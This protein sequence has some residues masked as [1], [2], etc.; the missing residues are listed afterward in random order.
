M[1]HEAAAVEGICRRRQQQSL[2][3]I[4][5]PH[6]RL[7][8]VHNKYWLAILHKVKLV[9]FRSSR[10]RTSIKA[11]HSL[12]FALAMRH[13]RRGNDRLIHARV[14]RVDVLDVGKACMVYASACESADC[15]LA[16]LA[17]RWAVT[18]VRC[19]A[20]EKSSI[21]IAGENCREIANLS[22]GCESIVHQFAL[23]SG[24]PQ[25]CHVSDLGKSVSVT[26]PGGRI[27]HRILCRP[28]SLCGS[29]S[30]VHSANN[31]GAVRREE[32]AV[33]G[34]T[35][36]AATAPRADLSEVRVISVMSSTRAVAMAPRCSLIFSLTS[37]SP[38]AL[39]I[40]F[41]LLLLFRIKF[42]TS[43]GDGILKLAAGGTTPSA[44]LRTVS[45]TGD[46]GDRGR[47]DRWPADDACRV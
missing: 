3:Y 35:S 4:P 30:R 26:L 22:R 24:V 7:A 37:S 6:M 41:V 12:L 29:D 17:A 9:E 13:R 14:S 16:E 11:G 25:F 21:R 15:R 27:E 18:R 36:A 46:A 8:V 34:S 45:L 43:T 31:A 20:L 19:F 32:N 39:R 40:C 38:E 10:H 1:A 2:R 44:S 47:L 42:L 5:L 28:M 23:S 33:E